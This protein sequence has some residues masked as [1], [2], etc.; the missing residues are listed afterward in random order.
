MTKKVQ[1]EAIEEGTMAM[2]SLQPASHPTTNDPKSKME[3]IAHTIG[4]MHAMK[5]DELTKW[6]NDAMALIGKETSHLPG[7]A[8]EPGNEASIRM[9]PSH[10]VGHQGP[11]PNMP[12]PK[13]GVKEDVDLSLIHI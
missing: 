9:K 10:A 7:S 12:M 3:Y 8:N 13:L 4:A 5:S 2:D 11:T 6:F 1:N